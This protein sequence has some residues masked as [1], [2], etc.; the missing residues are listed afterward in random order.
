MADVDAQLAMPKPVRCVGV[1]AA[2]ASSLLLGACAQM[3]GEE[4]GGLFAALTPETSDSQQ[5]PVK[6]SD[7]REA[8]EYWGKQYSKNPRDLEAALS[9]AQNLKVLG[10]KREALAVLQQA[11]LIHGTNKELAAEYGRLALDLDQISV[12]KKLLEIADDPTNPNWRVVMARGTALAKEGSYREAIGFFERA[13]AL[14]PGHPSV[15]NN[16]ALAYTMSGEAD[17]GEQLLRQA[18][19]S[20]GDNMKVRQNLAL[21]LGLQGK[22][23]EAT[24]LASVDLPPADAQA[25]TALLKK[26]VKLDAK[27]SPPASGPMEAPQELAAPAVATVKAS[28]GPAPTVRT[29]ARAASAP[30]LRSSTMETGFGDTPPDARSAGLFTAE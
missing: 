30:S 21:V 10:Q 2:I 28:P 11:S 3:S 14:N 9:Y 7:P 27:A 26:M 8:A 4:S 24:K 1:L 23:E 18:S 22:Y 15:L 13:Q 29:V 12:A 20:G 5:Q 6:P 17:R 19:T 16:L 25:N